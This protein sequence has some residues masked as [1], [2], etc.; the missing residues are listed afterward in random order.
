LEGF[1]EY[2]NLWRKFQY[3]G[4]MEQRRRQ[5]TIKNLVQAEFRAY[6]S[7]ALNTTA[8]LSPPT[9]DNCGSAG[10][11]GFFARQTNMSMSPWFQAELQVLY[12]WGK[13]NPPLAQSSLRHNAVLGR[14]GCTTRS[15]G[16]AGRNSDGK[17]HGARQRQ[18]LVGKFGLL[19]R[20]HQW[21]Q[22]SR[23]RTGV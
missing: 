9:P 18:D 22:R 2:K 19:G 20:R 23:R 8:H 1:T 11:N 4:I 14:H 16:K 10:E 17:T 6:P 5:K 12:S 3:I 15:D 21:L 13:S 7:T